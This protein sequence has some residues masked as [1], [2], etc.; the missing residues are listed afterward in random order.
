MDDDLQSASDSL[1][2]QPEKPAYHPSASKPPKHIP[3]GLIIGAVIAIVLAGA[4]FGALKLLGHK[5]KGPNSTIST[6]AAATQTTPSDVPD[7]PL[8]E[9]YNSTALSVAFKHPKT[10]KVSEAAGGIRIESPAFSYPAANLGNVDGLFRVYIRQGARTA[11]GKYIGDGLAIKPSEKLVY[12]QPVTGQRPDTLLSSFGS[13][14]TDIF[15]FFL[16]AGNFQLNQGDTLGPDYGKE[17][18]S[19]IVAGGYTTTTASD[20]LAMNSVALDYYATTNA[21]KQ[22]L[23]IIASLQLK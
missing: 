2:H 11:D 16:I 7:K 1:T 19:Y 10:W 20:D 14:S 23:A 4:G 21:Y 5:S 8:S 12:T 13:N 15:T 22:A 3:K 18:D 17:P 9:T 6:N